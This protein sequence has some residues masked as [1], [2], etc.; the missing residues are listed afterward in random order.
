M[1]DRL[2]GPAGTE[3]SEAPEQGYDVANVSDWHLPAFKAKFKD[4]LAVMAEEPTRGA[5]VPAQ[6]IKTRPSRLCPRRGGCLGSLVIATGAGHSYFGHD[7]WALVATALKT[8]E[9]ATMIRRKILIAL[10][11]AKRET[12]PDRRAA[13]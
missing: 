9:D 6:G 8:I 4:G 7:E 5:N 2:R 12:D 11:N 1:Q 13:C 3:Q 10:E